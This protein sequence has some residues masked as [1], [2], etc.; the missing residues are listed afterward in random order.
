MAYVYW[1]PSVGSCHHGM[2]RSL[3]FG[4][5]SRSPDMQANCEIFNKQSWTADQQRPSSLRLITSHCEN[6]LRSTW[7][8]TLREECRLRVFENR[9]LRRIFVPKRE[10]R[11]LHDEELHSLYRSPNII[12]MIKSRRLRY[13][14]HVARMKEGSFHNFNR[15]T[16]RKKTFRQAQAQMVGQYQNGP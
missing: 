4:W 10:W 16:Y 12:R 7:Y 1:L 15:Q 6:H 5:G 14:G 8:L 9:I 11:R 2:A 13:A 3:G